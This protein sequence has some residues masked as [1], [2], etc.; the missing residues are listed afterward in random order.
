MVSATETLET[1]AIEPPSDIAI[2]KIFRLVSTEAIKYAS[3][4]FERRQNSTT[5]L[6]QVALSRIAQECEELGRKYLALLLS[7]VST[8]CLK[9][10]QDMIHLQMEGCLRYHQQLDS[11]RNIAQGRRAD[12]GIVENG[13]FLAEE[14]LG[15]TKVRSSLL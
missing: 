7:T 6:D 5:H 10:I 4:E 1:A 9:G 3:D 12:T 13:V 14:A 2:S 8:Q 15:P 11:L